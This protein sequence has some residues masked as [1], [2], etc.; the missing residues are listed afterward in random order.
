MSEIAAH[1]YENNA[2]SKADKLKEANERVPFIVQRLD[3]QVNLK[4]NTFHNYIIK[5]CETICAK[6]IFHVCSKLSLRQLTYNKV[7]HPQILSNY[8]TIL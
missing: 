3:E 2:E 8:I 4:K 7:L 1:S 6:T 5:N